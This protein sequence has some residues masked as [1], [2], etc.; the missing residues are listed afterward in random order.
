MLHEILLSLSGQPS[1]LFCQPAE[2]GDSAGAGFPL[3]SPPEKALLASLARLSELHQLLRTHTSQI[4]SSHASTICRAVSTAIATEHLGKFQRKILEVEKA[5]LAID[6]DYVG[7]YGIVPLSTIVSEFTPWVRRMEWLWDIAQFMLPRTDPGNL[8]YIPCTAGKLINRLRK[9]V[10]TGHV[11][12][13]EM[14]MVLIKAAETAWMRQLSMWILYGQLPAIGREDF[15]IQV[16]A[17]ASHETGPRG[18]E[19]TLCPDLFPMFLSAPTAGSILFI[20]KSLN[21]IRMK[22]EFLDDSNSPAPN[23]LLHGNYIRYLSALS[24]PLSPVSL[25]SAVSEIR[26]SL[27]QT[28]LSKLLPLPKIVEVLSVLHDFLLLGRGEFAMALVVFADERL[29]SKH[30]RTIAKEAPTESQPF[31]LLRVQNGDASAVLS[32]AWAELYLLQNEEDP[33]DDELD[34]AREL[35][36]LTVETKAEEGAQSEKEPPVT[37]L[38]IDISNTSF[39]DLLFGGTPTKLSLNVKSPLDLFLAPSDMLIYSK[40][41]AYLLGIR[42]AQIRLSSLWKCTSIRRIHPAPWGPPLSNKRGSQ[43]QLRLRRERDR[44]RCTSM[45]GIW[46]ICNAARFVLSELGSYVQGEVISGSWLHFRRWLDGTKPLTTPGHSRPAT[47]NKKQADDQL[48]PSYPQHDPETINLAHR[49]YLSCI[50]QSVFLTDAAFTRSLRTLLNEVDRFILLITQLQ[51]V[52]KHVDL[53]N[54]EGVY[55][56]LADHHSDEQKIW[57]ELCHSRAELETLITELISRLRDIDDGRL[58]EGV[59]MFDFGSTTAVNSAHADVP[60][61]LSG[62]TNPYVPWRPA[63]VDRLLM[64]LDFGASKNSPGSFDFKEEFID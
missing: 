61:S 28:V 43:E 9:D 18:V 51:S 49:M 48:P 15:F 37:N 6:A 34:L 57:S 41:Y 55:D 62:P 20:G 24:S 52:Q 53:E 10:Q 44:K 54:D 26:L 17:A 59:R 35:L 13:E 12:L 16:V 29:L 58:A 2:E 27:S 63:G 21:H 31:D 1:P 33:I 45:R 25:S 23:I 5:I 39:D 60:P 42:R 19:Y 56:S 36:R 14:A 3:L 4:S 64:K 22:G 50:A 11:D 47:A 46:A 7:G 30:R 8:E 40:I 38:V 32:Q